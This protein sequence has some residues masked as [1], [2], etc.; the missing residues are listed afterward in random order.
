MPGDTHH[1]IEIPERNIVRYVPKELRYCSPTEFKHVARLLLDWQQGK[2]SFPEFKI[3]AI[4]LLMGLKK[5]KRKLNTI[6]QEIVFSNIENVSHVMDTFFTDTD[7]G[8]KR[9][10][11]VDLNNP[12]PYLRHLIKKVYG[13]RKRFVGTTYGQYEDALHFYAMYHKHEDIKFLWKLFFTYYQGK[14]YDKN[15]TEKLIQKYKALTDVVDVFSFFLF[16]E[17]FMDYVGSSRV[18]VEGNII[19]L[20]I[21][22]SAPKDGFKSK[23]P[24]LGAKSLSYFISKTGIVGN[25]EETRKTELWEML[26]LLYDVRKGE[27]D[28]REMMEQAK[29]N[30]KNG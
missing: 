6:E 27:L 20:S 26:L 22:F 1:I 16:F 9:I 30:Q 24:G 7:D 4:Y 21:I 25:L 29:R 28:E 18:M 13:P 8:Q 2:I 15:K 12:V 3:Q 23:I 11:L 19:D 10:K 17:S 14:D 5:V